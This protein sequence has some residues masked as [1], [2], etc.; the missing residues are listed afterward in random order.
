MAALATPQKQ[1]KTSSSRYVCYIGYNNDAQSGIGNKKAQKQLIK[2]H[3]SQNIQIR[4]IYV[5]NQYTLVED[6]DYN[7]Y[8]AGLNARGACT[9]K[10]QSKYILSMAPITYFKEMNL[11]I[12]QVFVSNSGDAPFWKTDNGSIY[13]SC[14]SNIDGRL[15]VAV[16][17]NKTINK[18]PFLSQLSI[19]KMV[20]G[21]W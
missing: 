12:S 13:T 1:T 11:K 18:I 14:K 20:S 3:W 15:G 5:A 21:Y 16:D 9:V 10:D 4:N 6:M 19:K 8:A 7:Y 2:C 17:R